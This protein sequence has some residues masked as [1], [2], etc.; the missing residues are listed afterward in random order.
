MSNDGCRG[1]RAADSYNG[2]RVTDGPGN[3][4][5]RV[6]EYELIPTQKQR[7][8]ISPPNGWVQFSPG[9]HT[10]RRTMT[11]GYLKQRMP[12][13]NT[14]ASNQNYVTKVM[15][16]PRTPKANRDVVIDFVLNHPER[17]MPLADMTDDP[18]QNEWARKKNGDAQFGFV[19]DFKAR[20]LGNHQSG[21]DHDRR[22]RRCPG[23]IPSI[24]RTAVSASVSCRRMVS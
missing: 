8:T 17:F 6:G 22:F 16:N 19:R 5:G 12:R 1:T 21:N 11:E 24:R 20:Y 7:G 3:V 4:S 13:T 14:I 9:V 18:V 10:K 2:S 15:E 23:T